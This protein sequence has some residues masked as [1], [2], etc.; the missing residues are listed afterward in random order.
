MKHVT[1]LFRLSDSVPPL[2]TVM[3]ATLT[4]QTYSSVPY[5]STYA[6]VKCALESQADILN[7][8]FNTFNY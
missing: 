8:I 5:S 2:C 1:K 6:V 7:S 4:E 3:P